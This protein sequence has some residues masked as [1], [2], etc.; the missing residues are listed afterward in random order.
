MAAR[1]N[2][3]K[4]K[5]LLE[6]SEYTAGQLESDNQ[7]RED[8][9]EAD[10]GQWSQERMKE[11][12]SLLEEE[13][14]QTAVEAKKISDDWYTHIRTRDKNLEPCFYGI[15]TTLQGNHLEAT[16]REFVFV[17]NGKTGKNERIVRHLAKSRDSDSYSKAIFKKLP[18]WVRGKAENTE[19]QLAR[20]RKRVRLIS[21]M[22]KTLKQ[23]E[24][25]LKDENYF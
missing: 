20:K 15:R 6:K 11:M 24:K 14:M 12:I 13:K 9:D 18:E 2:A 5:K 19:E 23:Y 3:E 22:V 17:K 21:E 1:P 10:L 4:L 25:L 7:E 8:L 16:W